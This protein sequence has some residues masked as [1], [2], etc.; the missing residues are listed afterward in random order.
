MLLSEGISAYR[1]E[2][3]ERVTESEETTEGEGKYC[4]FCGG[5]NDADAVFC[6]VCGK[7]MNMEDPMAG[8]SAEKSEE[9]LQK[10]G[11]RQ[12]K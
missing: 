2:Q 9:V 1:P 6:C 11:S 4:P 12:E 10:A 8:R 5:K 7:N 3:E